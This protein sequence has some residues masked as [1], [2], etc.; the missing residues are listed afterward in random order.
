MRGKAIM[1]SLLLFF[2]KPL[3]YTSKHCFAFCLPW[4][5]SNKV[6]K[7]WGRHVFLSLSSL[8]HRTNSQLNT[9]LAIISL[10]NSFKLLIKLFLIKTIYLTLLGCFRVRLRVDALG[11]M[12][13]QS[14]Y[15]R[16]DLSFHIMRVM[17]K[18]QK[19]GRSRWRQEFSGVLIGPE[20]HSDIAKQEFPHW[21]VRQRWP[22]NDEE[23][24]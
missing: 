17:A 7:V 22:D 10:F 20:R 12:Q 15:S 6:S 16:Y 19:N 1:Q 18:L 11:H 14:T 8:Q 24:E 3:H 9:L 2:W 5:Q 4:Q 23:V 21:L 13:K